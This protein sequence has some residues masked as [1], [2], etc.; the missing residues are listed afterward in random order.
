MKKWICIS[1]LLIAGFL[2]NGFCA[3]TIEIEITEVPYVQPYAFLGI[4]FETGGQRSVGLTADADSQ[5]DPKEMNFSIWM[6]SARHNQDFQ[7]QTHLG[8]RGIDITELQVENLASISGFEIFLGGRF[9]PRYPTFSL[10]RLP[11]RL[12]LSVLVYCSI[13]TITMA[14]AIFNP[15]SRRE[16]HRIPTAVCKQQA[17]QKT[18]KELQPEG[19]AIFDQF[20]PLF[21]LTDHKGYA[22]LIVR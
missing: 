8:Y 6:M 12:T 21:S 16:E 4:T 10:S 22:A 7:F 1:L 14:D 20:I 13:N 9:F 11:V 19:N 18:E 17:T 15:Y 5:I 2:F 3:E